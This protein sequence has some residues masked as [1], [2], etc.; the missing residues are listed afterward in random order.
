MSLKNILVDFK[1]KLNSL[2]QAAN[3][4]YF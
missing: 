3:F 1:I 2:W 4:T